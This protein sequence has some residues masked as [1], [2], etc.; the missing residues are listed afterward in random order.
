MGA[1]RSYAD[2]GAADALNARS[3]LL[4]A[5]ADLR[6]AGDHIQAN[7]WVS[8]NTD[9]HSAADALGAA[10]YDAFW[11]GGFGHS[12]TMFW[13]NAL[14]W[15]DDNWPSNGEEYEL[16]MDKILTAMWDSDKLRNF[17]FINYIDAMRGGIWNTE[18][19]ETHLAEWY[20]HFSL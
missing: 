2:A 3:H 12:L 4:S 1:I 11:V 14:Y 6:K 8:A 10:A 20:R 15:I 17:H 19:Y 9:I 7:Q 5:A 18:I 16:T 13:R